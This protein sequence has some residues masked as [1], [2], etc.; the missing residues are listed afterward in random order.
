LKQ[1]LSQSLCVFIHL[2]YDKCFFSPISIRSRQTVQSFTV[3]RVE[4]TD[5]VTYILLQV[6]CFLDLSLGLVFFGKFKE[7]TES[8]RRS[9]AIICNNL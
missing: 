3:G 9:I 6:S 4:C 8:I 2:L 5:W 1:L 7:Y